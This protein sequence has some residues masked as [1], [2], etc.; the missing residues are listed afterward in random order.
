MPV[1]VSESE[2]LGYLTVARFTP[3]SPPAFTDVN[4]GYKYV[5]EAFMPLGDGF[6]AVSDRDRDFFRLYR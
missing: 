5:P 4:L 3:I 1:T 2:R 6:A